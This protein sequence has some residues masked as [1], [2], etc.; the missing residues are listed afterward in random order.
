MQY[1]NIIVSRWDLFDHHSLK[2]TSK[3]PNHSVVV[4]ISGQ[5]DSCVAFSAQKCGPHNFISLDWLFDAVCEC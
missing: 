1:D 3:S 2:W 5:E 4:R